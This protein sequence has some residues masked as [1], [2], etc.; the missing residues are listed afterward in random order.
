MM[1]TSIE[2]SSKE[3]SKKDSKTST[4]S[5]QGSLSSSRSTTLK[6]L[7]ETQD[8]LNKQL[9]RGWGMNTSPVKDKIMKNIK[10]SVQHSQK[11]FR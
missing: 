8:K 3:S 7:K 4:S 10:S 11:T 9:E 2:P 1:S 6:K 5:S